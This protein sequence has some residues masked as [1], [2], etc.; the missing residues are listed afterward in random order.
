MTFQLQLTESDLSAFLACLGIGT[1]HA[2]RTG[3]LPAEAGI[4]T[5]GAPRTWG[6]ISGL[7][8]VSQ[9]ILDVFQACDELSAIQKLM[10]D[11]FD[12]TITQL[13]D[14]L[15]AELSNIEDPGWRITWDSVTND[16]GGTE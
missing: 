11:G 15:Q 6:P 5:L 9:E 10:P 12:A 16:K 4:W 14:R 7:P 8:F 3:I 13:I 2:I 1:L